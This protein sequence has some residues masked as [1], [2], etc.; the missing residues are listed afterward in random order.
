MTNKLC[1]VTGL[2]WGDEGK[3]AIVDFLAHDVSVVVSF[4]GGHNAGHTLIIDGKKTVLHLIPSGIL[5]DQVECII[6][7]CVVVSLPDLQH[8]ISQLID[9]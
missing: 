7:G 4:Q 9:A 2:Q 6:S 8:E 5:R 3:G 1:L